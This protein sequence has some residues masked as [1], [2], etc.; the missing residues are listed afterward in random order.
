MRRTFGIT[1]L[2]TMLSCSHQTELMALPEDL[3][4]ESVVLSN[5]LSGGYASFYPE[6]SQF[7]EIPGHS[8]QG[9]KSGVAVLMSMG[10][11]AGGNTNNQYVAVYAIN[12]KLNLDKRYKKYR[13]VSFKQV[14]GKGDRLFTTISSEN[15]G[16]V[17]SGFGYGEKDSLCCPSQ[18][19]SL[20][21]TMS[22][23]GH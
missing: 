16:L 18:P 11:W 23:R 2:L 14:G 10:G 4:K 7:V 21:L 22:A 8:A 1:I 6:H 17:L 20:M 5:T 13:L 19:I 15:Q 9:F 3:V 12:E